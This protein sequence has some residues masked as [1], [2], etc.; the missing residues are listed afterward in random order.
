MG[1]SVKREDVCVRESKGRRGVRESVKREDVCVR[2]S[3]G[4]R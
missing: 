3:R 1:E 4:R 2:E